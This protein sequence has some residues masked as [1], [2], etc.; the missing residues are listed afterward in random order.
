MLIY[1]KFLYIFDPSTWWTPLGLSLSQEEQ[2]WCLHITFIGL[3][4]VPL[5]LAFVLRL[6]G[7]MYTEYRHTE[8]HPKFSLYFIPYIMFL[9]A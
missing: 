8:Q 5:V 3:S 9:L 2:I 1:A 7:P 6:H 4:T